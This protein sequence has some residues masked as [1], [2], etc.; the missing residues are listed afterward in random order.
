MS[1]Q[2]CKSFKKQNSELTIS[3]IRKGGH[4]ILGKL[5]CKKCKKMEIVKNIETKESRAICGA[6]IVNGLTHQSYDGFFSLI[7]TDYYGRTTYTDIE[8]KTVAPIVETLKETSCSIMLETL[9]ANGGA[10]IGLDARYSSGRN[11]EHCT[12]TAVDQFNHIVEC[13]SAHSK[14]AY[15]KDGQWS[16]YAGN[17]EIHLTKKILEKIGNNGDRY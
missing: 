15:N 2:Q 11:A 13:K 17:L 8:Q 1:R 10:V 6:W 12:V 14:E 3:L 5:V 4:K 16:N 9:K 7:S